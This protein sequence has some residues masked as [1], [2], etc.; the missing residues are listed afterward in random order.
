LFVLLVASTGAATLWQPMTGCFYQRDPLFCCTSTESC[1]AGDAD[2]PITPCTD[3]D[4]PYCDDEGPEGTGFFGHGRTCIADPGGPVCAEADVCPDDLPVCVGHICVQCD[5]ATR[6]TDP[7]AP[8]CDT[9]TNRCEGCAVDPDCSP[10]GDAPRCWAEEGTCVACLGPDD[11]S[12]AAPLC[13]ANR[14]VE[15]A[16]SGDCGGARPVCGDDKACRGCL[17]DAECASDVCDEEGGACFDEATVLYVS[18][19]G[20][21][22]SACTRAEPCATFARALQLVSETRR[23]IKAAPGTYTEQIVVEGVAATVLADGVTVQPP[24]ANQTVV[25]VAAGADVTIEGLTVTGAAGAGNTVALT[26]TASRLHLRRSTVIANTGGGGVS[27]SGCEFSLVNNVIALNGNLTSPF[28]GV[29]ISNVATE[30]L[31]EFSFNTVTGNGGGTNAITGVVCAVINV[32][33]TFSNNIAY[34]NLVSGSGTQVGGDAQCSW[35][36]SDIGPDTVPGTGNI[37]EDP[38]F[39]DPENRDFHLQPTSPARDAAEPAATLTRDIDGDA[40]PLGERSDMGA[41]EVAT[42]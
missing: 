29:Q 2:E 8:V 41:D 9:A 12:G 7:A 37:N 13:D 32:S 3:P 24:A 39:L 19:T 25:E 20:Q 42:R 26:C 28:G 38:A 5:D 1:T 31:H 15:C 33:L 30:G 36:Y 10:F 22:D 35:I 17:A 14:C 21:P 16:S 27:I 34:G 18:T 11:C 6:C 40:R 4:R 23:V